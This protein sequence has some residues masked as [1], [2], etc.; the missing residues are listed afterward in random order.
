MT[1]LCD[2]VKYNSSSNTLIAAGRGA[3]YDGNGRICLI[4]D[5]EDCSSGKYTC[6]D[7]A[8]ISFK[9]YRCDS[10]YQCSD[11]SD[12]RRCNSELSKRYIK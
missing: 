8:C 5:A 1:P 10:F 6:D 2:I 4:L 12:E 9:S 7:G 3:L 11:L